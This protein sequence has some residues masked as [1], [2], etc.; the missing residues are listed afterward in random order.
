MKN[1]VVVLKRKTPIYIA[2]GRITIHE[3]DETRTPMFW[4]Y[5]SE[6][7][8]EDF[9]EIEKVR[10]FFKEEYDNLYPRSFDQRFWLATLAG[11]REI[12]NDKDVARICESELN[13]G[14][15]NPE[16]LEPYGILES[17]RVVD[18]KQYIAN[19]LVDICHLDSP[20]LVKGYSNMRIGRVIL[21]YFSDDTI[22]RDKD[23]EDSTIFWDMM[24]K[25]ALSVWETKT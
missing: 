12:P 16:I 11:S 23:V 14:V 17:K 24:K 3:G 8:A 10:D 2:Y 15:V 6:S 20:F 7:A 19:G 5:A 13:I 21:H 1:D 4:P 18:M 25:R 22:P 9:P